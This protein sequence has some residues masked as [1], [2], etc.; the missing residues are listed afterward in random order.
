MY[1]IKARLVRDELFASNLFYMYIVVLYATI[2]FKC[3]TVF[4]P[5]LYATLFW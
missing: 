1:I 2:L 3:L 5:Y 4:L